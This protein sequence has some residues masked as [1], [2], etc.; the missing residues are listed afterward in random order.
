MD[1]AGDGRAATIVDVGHRTGDSTRSRYSAEDR[2]R[3][4]GQSLS[5]EFCVGAMTVADDTVGHSSR[6]QRLDGTEDGDG[7]GW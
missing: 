6:K 4:V 2:R 3:Q 7:D 1:D 5:D